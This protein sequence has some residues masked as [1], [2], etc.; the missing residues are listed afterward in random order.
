M[1]EPVTI[2]VPSIKRVLLCAAAIFVVDA[3]VV[4]QGAI[5]I[6][7][8]LWMLFGALPLTS[9]AKYAGVRGER[10][11]NIGVYVT[12]CVLVLVYNSVNNDIANERA[13]TVVKAIKAYHAKYQRYP[14]TL[15][16]IAPEFIAEIPR[17]KYTVLS[18]DFRYQ[19]LGGKPMLYYQV[20]PPFGTRMYSFD[21]GEWRMRS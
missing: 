6:C 9:R 15:T 18:G 4:N 5:A 8:A 12:G 10:L 7:V 2:S 1:S 13:E 21:S 17:A 16:E 11:R 20:M 14:E 3:I 19:P